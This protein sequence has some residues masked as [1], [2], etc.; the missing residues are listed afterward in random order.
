M[1]TFLS[2]FI[3]RLEISPYAEHETLFA[4]EISNILEFN[5]DS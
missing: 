4:E 2:Y 5:S 3:G 1:C